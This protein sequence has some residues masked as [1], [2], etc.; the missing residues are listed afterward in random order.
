M[1][2]IKKEK[3]PEEIEQDKEKRVFWTRAI[4][5]SLFSCFIPVAFIGWRYDLFRK[6]GSLQLSGWGLM[7][8]VI[9]FVFLYVVVK[10]VRVGFVEWSMTKQVINGIVKVVL[11]LGALLALCIG[12]RNSLDTFI[13]AL[14]CVLVSEVIAIPVNPFPEWVWKKS[15][16]RFEGMVDFVADRFYNKREEHKGE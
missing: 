12:L 5:W 4:I 1:K 14:S 13:Q 6:A 2:K 7:A 10:Y 11:P 16:G 8:I 15:K 9:I 3:T